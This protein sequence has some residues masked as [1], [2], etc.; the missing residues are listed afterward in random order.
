MAFT[1]KLYKDEIIIDADKIF[2]HGDPEAFK[3]TATPEGLSTGYALERRRTLFGAMEN[4]PAFG[5]PTIPK[6]E[7][8][9]RIEEGEALGSFISQRMI[10]AKIPCKDQQQTNF[11][12]IF[13]TVSAYECRRMLQGETYINFS[14]ASCGSL[15]TNGRNIGG[16]CEQ[17]ING[18]H[19][20]GLAPSDMYSS[21]ETRKRHSSDLLRKMKTFDVPD[22]CELAPRNLNDLITA[23][24]SYV[25]L[26]VGLNWWGH[27]ILFCEPVWLDGT[28]AYRFRNSWGSSYGSNGFSILQGSKMLPDDA[29]GVLSVSP[30]DRGDM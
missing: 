26:A 6:S 19:K 20:Y 1:S 9:A 18:I 24:L 12:W 2:Q 30:A 29:I 21:T 4:A 27:A 13:S 11:C 22:F 17:A 10:K 16:W 14:P 28:V 5:L 15:I 7:W 23:G 25:P 3:E 8:Q